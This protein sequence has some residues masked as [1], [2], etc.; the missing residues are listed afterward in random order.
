[1]TEGHWARSSEGLDNWCCLLRVV[2]GDATN[3]WQC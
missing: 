2:C 1:M 3:C